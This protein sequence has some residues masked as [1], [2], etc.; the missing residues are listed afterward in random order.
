LPSRQMS[1][2][3][4]WTRAVLRATR[5]AR[6]SARPTATEKVLAG[7]VRGVVLSRNHA[8]ESRVPARSVCA[9]TS[10]FGAYRPL[11][12]MLAAHFLPCAKICGAAASLSTAWIRLSLSEN[13]RGVLL[14]WQ[15]RSGKAG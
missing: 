5:P 13:S 12:S 4:P 14:S 2:G 9:R 11:A 8:I 6:R 7:L 15:G 10:S 3:V 1:T